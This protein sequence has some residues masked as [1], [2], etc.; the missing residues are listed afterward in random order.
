MARGISFGLV[1]AIV[2]GWVA[3]GMFSQFQRKMVFPGPEGVSESLLHDVATQVGATELRILTEDG[4]TLYGWH[5][6]AI[7]SGSRRVV[8]YFHGNASSLLAQ[9]E[10]QDLLLS[11]GWDFVG[12]HYRGYPGSTGVPSETGLHKDAMA[13]W[14]WLTDELGVQPDRV[15][16][17]GR[18]LGGGVAVQL[19]AAVD[20]GALVL[21]STFTSIVDLAKEHYRW[22]PAGSVLEHRFMTRDFAGRISCPLLVAHGA[23]DSIIDVQHGKELARLFR[24]DEYIEV[25]RVDHNDML[26]VGLIATR[27]LNFLE[28]AVPAS[29][30]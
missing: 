21:E 22:L 6:A 25:P 7:W 11:E 28:S 1:T 30:Q 12:I 24:A 14:K 18:S 4:E 16:V 8:L 19:A 3:M 29:Q 13:A 15:A 2:A 17:H 10:L 26:L 9:L 23:A 27:Y 20:P 5:R